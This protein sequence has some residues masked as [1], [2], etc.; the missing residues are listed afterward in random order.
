MTVLERDRARSA[1]PFLVITQLMIVLDASTVNIA[2]PSIGRDLG[3]SQAGLQWVINAYTLT[4]GGFLMLGG[5]MADLLGR[6]FVFVSGLC[7]FGLASLTAGLAPVAGVLIVARAVQG[8]AAA[9][10]SAA[11]LSIIVSLFPEGNDRNRALAMWG[12]V[13]GVGGAIG[14]IFGGVLTSGPG[15]SWIFYI[16]VPIAVIVV[17]AVRGRV[18]GKRVEAPGRVDV[19]GAVTLTGGL[20]LLVYAIVSAKSGNPATILLAL[21]L[22]V[23]LLVS[24]F[25]VEGKVREPLVPLSSFRNRNLS[26]ASLVGLFAGAAPYAMFFLLSLDLQN[27]L[28]LT[29][30]EA[31]FGFLPLSLVSMAGAAALAPLLMAKTS[32]RFTLVLSLCMLGSGLFLLSRL[33]VGDGF[34]A[35]VPGQL[36]AGLGLGTTF[37]AVTTAAVKGLAEGQSGLASGLINTSQQLGGALGLGGLAALSGAYSAAQLAKPGV[38]EAMALSSGYQVAFRGAAAL[39]VIGALIALLL[40]ARAPLPAGDGPCDGI[41]ELA[42]GP[43]LQR[44]QPG[45]R[46]HPLLD[47]QDLALGDAAAQRACQGRA[48]SRAAAVHQPEL[49]GP[50]ERQ[51]DGQSLHLRVGE[52]EEVPH[53]NDAREPDAGT[54]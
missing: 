38:H 43:E 28:G 33:S 3:M 8:L 31:G 29:P 9:V 53:A 41:A 54:R 6:R 44:R 40:P 48:D 26:V 20:T 51:P 1:L 15:W 5:R 21:S 14:V 13:S 36:V 2:L 32:P 27:V 7:L 22:A 50:V 45:S 4:F 25:V 37:V 17:M 34:G 10:S 42:L 24:F 16:N 39:A 11:A 52:E 49:G 19:T 46:D 47:P 30:L 23:V 12:A 18:P 35:T